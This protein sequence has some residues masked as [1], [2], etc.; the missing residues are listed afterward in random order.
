MEP[1]LMPDD[2]A[3][4]L[5]AARPTYAEVG[6][7]AGALP[8]GYRHLRRTVRVG[9]GAGLFEAAGDAL[10]GWQLHLRA[11]LRVTVSSRT[12]EP[13]AVVELGFGAGPFR[14]TA[15]CRVVYAVAE[16]RRRGFAYG[17]L[18]GHPEQG[19][20]SFVIEHHD[21][22]TVHF[23]ITAFSRPAGLAARLAGPAGRAVQRRVTSRYLGASRLLGEVHT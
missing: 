19:E 11:G 15:P 17:T 2:V 12:A 18:P 4:R 3:R 7:T 9:A 13:G 22:G 8:A 21:D 6:R 14:L 20:E 16:A 1:A 23:A 10:L 5:G